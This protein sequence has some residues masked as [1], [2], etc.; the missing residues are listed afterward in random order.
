MRPLARPGGKLFTHV[1]CHRSLAYPY[2]DGD[3][4]MERYFFTGGIMP[5][6]DLF[7]Q[8][9]DVMTVEQRWWVDGTHYE[10]TSNAWLANRRAAGSYRG[11]VPRNLWSRW[12]TLAALAH[13]LHGLRGALGMD[14]GQT[15]GVVHSLMRPAADPAL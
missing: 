4:W 6:E 3:G 10:R 1:F 11:A 14:R 12:G 9:P 2:A 7:E 5:R 13:V 15:Y 8:F